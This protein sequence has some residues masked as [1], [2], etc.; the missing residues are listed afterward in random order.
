MRPGE[1]YY[2][3]PG[4]VVRLVLWGTATVV[5]V[6]FIAV[7]TGTSDGLTADLGRAADQLPSTGRQLLLALTQVA[8]IVVPA[9]VAVVLVVS[10]RWRRLGIVLAAGAL[11]ALIFEGLDAAF[12]L[13]ESLPGAVTTGTWVASTTVPLAR[14]PGGR[15]RRQRRRQ[16]VAVPAVA[17]GGRPRPPRARSGHGDRRHRGSS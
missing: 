4:D 12:D 10:R 2:R 7:A 5:L 13:S 1:R 6:L 14:L 15:G 17:T 11:G 3:H 8:A 16:A 9:T